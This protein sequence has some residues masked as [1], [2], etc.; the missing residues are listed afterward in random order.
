VT[1]DAAGT[2]YTVWSDNHNAYLAHSSDGGQTWSAPV[3]LNKGGA[4]VYPTAAGG[5]AGV[6]KVA[7]YGTTVAGDVNDPVAMGTPGAPG[8]AQ[9]TVQVATS[10]NYGKG[11]SVAAATYTV[12]TGVLCTEGDN[13]SIANSRDLYDDFGAAISPAT[14]ILSVAYTSDQPGSVNANDFT[15]YATATR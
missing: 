7:Y 6:V 1:T 14:G 4:A 15:G 5:S 12:H 11:F 9:W 10:T 13:C 8:A 2:V 3:Q